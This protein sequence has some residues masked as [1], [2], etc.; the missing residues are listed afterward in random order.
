MSHQAGR[1][2]TAAAPAEPAPAGSHRPA[3]RGLAAPRGWA[4]RWRRR[5]FSVRFPCVALRWRLML[6]VLV[7]TVPALLLF[8]EDANKDRAALVAEA[9]QKAMRLARV[10]ADNH[11]GLLREAHLLIE[12]VAA[13]AQQDRTGDEC[14]AWLAMLTTRAHWP[15]A[16]AII[17]RSGARFCTS[18]DADLAL[19]RLSTGFL[20]DVLDS[21]AVQVSEFQLAPGNRSLAFAALNLP[22]AGDGIERA[23][24]V[25]IE[26]AEIQR[27]T[28]REAE[29]A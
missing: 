5:P 12:A 26:L 13:R 16:V 7:P 8:F 29:G 19:N 1:S 2:E 15:G 17:G 23:V 24:V 6:L 25:A 14:A 21:S 27:R 10:W 18:H 3:Q 28:T 20:E 22:P 9:E 11:D 4:W